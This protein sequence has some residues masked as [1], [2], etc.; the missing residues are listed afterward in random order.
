MIRF[1]QINLHRSKVADELL[2]Q[3]VRENEIDIVL[4][5]EPYLYSGDTNWVLDQTKT[6]AIWCNNRSKAQVSHNGIGKGYAW[7]TINNITIFSC[8]L[9]PNQTTEQYQEA[10]DRLEDE[11]SQ[12]DGSKIIGGDINAKAVEWGT[13]TTNNRGQK[14][15][16][17][18][19]RL[20]LYVVNTGST[21]TFRR[22]GYTETI[23]DVTFASENLIPLINE[24]EVLE[25][26]S[27]SDH[28][29]IKFN[30]ETRPK[31]NR[32][33]YGN[34]KKWNVSKLDISKLTIALQRSKET[35]ERTLATLD[36]PEIVVEK[37]MA[38]IKSACGKS[39]PQKGRARNREPVYWWTNEIAELRGK[40]FH[41]R[42]RAQRA[43][44]QESREMALVNYQIAR[45]ALR[46]AIKRS[47][48]NKWNLLVNQVA[49]DPWGLGYKI[50]MNKIKAPVPT[51]NLPTAVMDQIV[52]TLFPTHRQRAELQT[53]LEETNPE[54]PLFTLEELNQ[55]A[56]AIKNGKAPGPDGVPNEVIKLI[57]ILQPNLLLN[58][59]NKCILSGVFSARWKRAKLVLIDK[60]KGDRLTAAAYRPL[61]MLDTTGKLFE[62][63]LKRRIQAHIAEAGG[64]SRMQFGFRQG[65]STLDAINVVTKTALST[66]IGNHSCRKIALL[67]TLDVKNAFNSANWTDILEALEQRFRIPAYL[68]KMM[69]NYLK[70]RCVI[71]KTEEGVK[72]KRVT[73]GVAQGSILGPELWNILYDDLLELEMPEGVLLVGFADDIAAIII[74]RTSEEAQLKL[75][76]TMRRVEMWM[77]EH[78]LI[79]ATHKTEIVVLTKRRIPTIFEMEVNNTHIVTKEATRYLGVVIDSKLSFW[80]HIKQTAERAGNVTTKLSRLLA[81]TRGPPECK[82]RLYMNVIHSILLYGAEIWAKALQKEY[83]RKR[84]AAAQRKGALR[85]ACS[86]RTV[87]E[88]AVNVIANVIP[89]DLLARER[90]LIFNR[91]DEITKAEAIADARRTI[92][93]SWQERWENEARGRWT[94]F[95]IP[96]LKQWSERKHGEINF[97]V[98]Q[99]L[100][101]H[102]YFRSYLY[103]MGKVSNPLC[104]LC[105][106]QEDTPQH[107]FFECSIGEQERRNINSLIGQISPNNIVGKMMSGENEWKIISLYVEMVLRKKKQIGFLQEPTHE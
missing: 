36:D 35:N 1:L 10:L 61:C 49:Q 8:Y 83:C 106:Q 64:L 44:N 69:R 24:W 105:D 23:P 41:L 92:M 63:L 81:N 6:A 29:Y 25:N 9:T 20:N 101:G 68:L 40:C 89:I 57:A 99:L 97:Y 71:Y 70:N 100:S 93:N 22:P 62:K 91:N 33:K 86:Y 102:G 80:E 87:S 77:Q 82:R 76:Q 53:T 79:L 74:S 90:Q 28:Q 43:N 32:Q 18:I 34:E 14:V 98:T 103:K 47:K 30:L 72:E 46:S 19:A 54:I 15:V 11:I 3:F 67:V 13:P 84:L 52:D 21:S 56:E 75:N 4:V 66:E 78:S 45:K 104:L 59:F 2:K 94:A 38:I 55:A 31:R 60:G 42:R 50:V 5:S 73:S 39:M 65:R 16:E 95:L 26:Y 51:T 58:M 96:E 85:V 88:A 48:K 12:K 37:T 17:M 7:I 107:T 27:A